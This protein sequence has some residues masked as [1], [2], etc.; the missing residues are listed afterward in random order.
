MNTHHNTQSMNESDSCTDIG[1]MSE[2]PNNLP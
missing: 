1:S 2:L